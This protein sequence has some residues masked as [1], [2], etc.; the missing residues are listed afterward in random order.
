MMGRT[1]NNDFIRL[2]ILSNHAS[3]TYHSTISNFDTLHNDN[4]TSNPDII[5]Y[6]R[7]FIIRIKFSR[8]INERISSSIYKLGCRYLL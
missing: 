8:D 4:M 5:P 2:N 1:A 6:P 7:N 3:R